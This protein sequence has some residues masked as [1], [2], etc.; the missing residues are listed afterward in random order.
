MHNSNNENIPSNNVAEIVDDD[1]DDDSSTNTRGSGRKKLEKISSQGYLCLRKKI[2][3]HAGEQLEQAKNICIETN[4]NKVLFYVNEALAKID[5]EKCDS[6][7]KK[8]SFKIV[9]KDKWDEIVQLSL[10]AMQQNDVNT[11]ARDNTASFE[12]EKA[13]IVAKTDMAKAQI[14]ASRDITLAKINRD[15]TLGVLRV[16]IEGIAGIEAKSE[17]V[18]LAQIGALNTALNTILEKVAPLSISPSFSPRK[19]ENGSIDRSPPPLPSPPPPTTPLSKEELTPS[20][21]HLSLFSPGKGGNGSIDRSPQP[22]NDKLLT[23]NKID[24]S[25][26][27]A[28]QSSLSLVN[29]KQEARQDEESA[30][31]SEDDEN[32]SLDN[33]KLLTEKKIDTSVKAAVQSSLSL[34]NGKQEAR[35]D[36]ESADDSEDDEHFSLCHV[37]NISNYSVTAPISLGEKRATMYT[38]SRKRYLAGVYTRAQ[39]GIYKSPPYDLDSDSS[40][41]DK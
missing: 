25:V 19:E 13:Q 34:V 12:L 10:A 8:P 40:S 37:F 11:K 6:T 29:G 20:S 39:I 14:E 32:F 38:M 1:T 31:D 5:E 18:Q 4:P 2:E 15:V 27:A 21:G 16:A 22:D 24:T 35:Q 36:E 7:I 9:F 28:V 33:D 26:K 41:S 3:D 23:E 17:Q 30:D